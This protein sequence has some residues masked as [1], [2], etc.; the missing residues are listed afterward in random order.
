[1]EYQKIANL[2]DNTF[3]QLSKFRTRNWVEINDDSR[4]AYTNSDIKFKSA[5]LKSNLCDYADAYILA[6][7]II[8]ITGD[9]DDTAARRVDERNKGVIFKNC[10]PFTKCISRINGT[11]ID[12][13]Q[14]IDIVMPMYNL[15]KYSNNYSKTSESL[16]QYYKDVPNDNL[17][18]SESFKYKVKIMG[19][20]PN[21]GNM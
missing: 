7:G 13:T 5:M 11:D 3:N 8:A 15:I 19:N 4:G 10:A 2:L 18:D 6:K 21:N 20:T 14:D 1:M 12:N 9:G 17:T 16:W